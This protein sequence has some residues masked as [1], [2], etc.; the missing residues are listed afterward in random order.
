MTP[1]RILDASALSVLVIL[2]SAASLW[3]QGSDA[4]AVI[5]EL[6]F[7]RGDVQ[8]RLPGKNNSE[9]AG[10]LQSLAPGTR[11]TATKDAAAVVLFTDGSKTITVNEKN[12]PFEIAAAPAKGQ[13][14]P[15]GQVA[16]L[17]LGKKKPP[18]YG[19]AA[20]R[21]KAQPPTLLSPR[22]TKISSASPTLQWM[23][24][25]Q[26]PGT[27]K[28]FGPQGVIWSAENINLTKIAYPASAPK[29]Q[30]EIDYAWVIERKGVAAGKT[31]FRL[32][33]PADAQAIKE[34]LTELSAMS[35]ASKTTLAV[36][37]A[38]FL[39]S[40][41]LF[42]D[43]RETLAEAIAADSDEPTLHFLLGEIYE[44]TGL[45]SLA[46]AEYGEAEFLSKNKP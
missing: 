17:L 29:L 37:K 21:G 10:V 5:T 19:A 42:H 41:D 6:K 15:L 44:K 12:S 36:L 3:A 16:S 33:R 13:G 45:K 28:V 25:D 8:V 40:K 35:G 18:S 22:N 11:V 4:V 1:R 43:A 26:Q 30:P 24:M 2:I 23:G 7:N 20:V 32:L 31:T 39:M 9:R 34:R 38:N 14:N 27:V 46:G